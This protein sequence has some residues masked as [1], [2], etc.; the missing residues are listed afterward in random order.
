MAQVA[1]GGIGLNLT[2]ANNAI[3]YSNDWSSELRLQS[4]DRIH[5]A[6]QTKV[7]SYYDLVVPNSVDEMVL[8]VLKNKYDMAEKALDEGYLERFL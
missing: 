3:Y 8:D 6:G 2:A 4:E 5:R 1:T 7:C